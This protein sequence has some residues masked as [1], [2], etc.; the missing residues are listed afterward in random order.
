MKKFPWIMIKIK[1]DFKE[2]MRWYKMLAKQGNMSD[3]TDKN[4][5]EN[6]ITLMKVYDWLLKIIFHE[7]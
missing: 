2:V 4:F 6:L 3:I 7:Q 1:K 5:D